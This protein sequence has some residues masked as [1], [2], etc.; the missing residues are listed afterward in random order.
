MMPLWTMATRSVAIGWALVSFGTPCVAQRVWPMPMR[1]ATGSAATRR[2]RLSSLPSA[3]R[4]SMRP[5]TSVAMPA[6]SS[7]RY[8]RRFSPSSSSGAAAPLP[9]MPTMPHIRRHPSPCPL[10]LTGARVSHNIAKSAKASLPPAFG[11]GLG[12]AGGDFGLALGAPGL[13]GA[14][15]GALPRAAQGERV[16]RHVVGDDAA[17][18]DHRARTDSQW[19]DQGR[20]GADEH[21]LADVGAEFLDA[22]VIA[23]D[24]AGA[25]VAALAHRAVAEIGQMVRLD[26]RRQARILH[27]DEIADVDLVGKLRTGTQARKRT[28]AG[29]VAYGGA[30]DVAEGWNLDALAHLH[31]R[32]EHHKRTDDGVAAELGVGAEED[33][34]WRGE[35]DAGFHRGVAQTLLH[36][37][38][39][40][41]ELVA[42]IDAQQLGGVAFG[43]ATD[44]A[45]AAR[46]ADDVGEILLAL[47][48]VRRKLRDEIEQNGRLGQHHAG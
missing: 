18:G 48:V 14:G 38:F 42:R 47:R 1:P 5:F 41:G 29:V 17:G 24:G 44:E 26:A 30:D 22:V 3:R 11:G 35:G 34:L 23:G 21:A 12:V 31:A 33:G 37:R 7:P 43:R 16:G 28:D 6:E 4:R 13:G 25:D 46:Q 40:I 19:S 20:I 32:P 45:L 36:H 39:G 27:L 8:S 2:A 15:L 9:T 10:P